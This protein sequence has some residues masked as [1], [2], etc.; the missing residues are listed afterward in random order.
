MG[1]P[2]AEKTDGD[3]AI[4][5]GGLFHKHFT[6]CK[7]EYAPSRGHPVFAETMI[8]LFREMFDKRIKP[9]QQWTEVIYQMLLT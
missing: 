5:N 4:K 7:I 8:K 6:D 1:N 9:N 2:P 3:G